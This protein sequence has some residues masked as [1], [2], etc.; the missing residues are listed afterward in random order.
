M[1]RHSADDARGSGT[2]SIRAVISA[3]LS[4]REL[5]VGFGASSLALAMPSRLRA[6]GGEGPSS[7][8]F[9]ELANT[10]D[11]NHRVAPGYRADVL[12]RWGDP[13]LPDAP[14]FDAERLRL[15]AQRKQFGYNADY[16]AWMPLPVGSA[17]SEHGLLC[18][19]HEYTTAPMM[20][21]GQGS[22]RL[23]ARQVAIEIAAHGLSVVE[24][25]RRDGRW[26]REPAGAFNRRLTAATP[27]RLSGPAAGHARLRTAA[28]PSGRRVLGTLNNCAGGV[29]PWGTVLTAEENLQRYFAGDPQQTPEARSLQRYGFG[30]PECNWGE[31]VARF[32]LAR[33]PREPNRFG[34]IVELDPYDALHVPAKRTALGRF[35]HEGASVALDPDGRVA[36]YSG[37]DEAFEY[38]YKFVSNGRYDPSD[39]AANRDLLDDGTLFVARFDADG[40]GTWLP[41]VFGTGPLTPEN[42]FASQADVLIEAR[43][44]A[45]LLG[46]T[47]MDR[48]EDI[49]HDPRSGRVWVMLTNNDK[50]PAARVDAANPRANNVHGHVLE[51]LP[52]DGAA[53]AHAA[54]S[55]R[56]NVFLLA[57]NPADASHGAAYHPQVSADGWFAAPDNCAID[58][59]GRLWIATDQGLRQAHNR[60]PD[61]LRACDTSGPGRALPR[62]C[63]ACPPGA[64][65]CGPAFTPDGT[66]LFV[67][68][69]HPGEGSSF[70]SPSTRWPDFVDGVPPRPSVVAITKDDG[71]EIGG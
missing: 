35:K 57:G 18:V 55:F 69:Q 46:A 28:D 8:T 5:L 33:E 23:S 64:E 27:M 16:I 2:P 40:T 22:Q 67:S 62:L 25:R 19:N 14:A 6:I 63:F 47:H 7:L 65:C 20:W 48:P 3:R 68:V 51:L 41:L 49:E 17:S 54:P 39:R 31:H 4:R 10:I 66:T 11:G 29:T 53:I 44:A 26:S 15:A 52:G 1:E 12:I 38:V 32:D 45:D 71:G 21:S 56:W 60:I 59:R 34:W 61:G 36:V 24:V 13:V 42:G 9:R 37:D 30:R 58:R 70:D 43:R 50:R